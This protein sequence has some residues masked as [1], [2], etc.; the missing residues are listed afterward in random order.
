MAYNPFDTSKTPFGSQPSAAD[1]F[2]LIGPA[3]D[4]EDDQK[5]QQA[6]PPPNYT[7][8]PTDTTQPSEQP[9]QGGG[10]PL[11]NL[12]QSAPTS[13]PQAPATQVIGGQQ[14]QVTQYQAPTSGQNVTPT[15]PP[16]VTMDAGMAMV[17]GPGG[18]KYAADPAWAARLQ[19]AAADQNEFYRLYDEMNR[20]VKSPMT[21]PYGWSSGQTLPFAGG[22]SSWQDDGSLKPIESLDEYFGFGGGESPQLQPPASAPAGPQGRAPL[23]VDPSQVTALPPYDP[24]QPLSPT[25]VWGANQGYPAGAGRQPGAPG[26]AVPPGSVVNNG[27]PSPS[28]E[29]NPTRSAVVGGG[30][31]PWLSNLWS[32]IQQ[33]PNFGAVNPSMPGGTADLNQASV[34]FAKQGLA[35]PS[36]YDNDLF[37]Q[38]MQSGMK[39]LETRQKGDRLDLLRDSASRLGPRSGQLTNEYIDLADRYDTRRHDM[40]T[41]LLREA[42]TTQAGDRLAA[43][44]GAQQVGSNV[45]GQEQSLRGETRQEREFA[46]NDRARKVNELI[47]YGAIDR[48][49]GR[50]AMD[51]Y[52]RWYQAEIAG[53]ESMARLAMQEFMN[54]IALAQL[55]ANLPSDGQGGA[56]NGQPETQDWLEWNAQNPYD[57]NHPYSQ[58]GWGNPANTGNYNFG[59]RF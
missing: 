45:F 19:A 51:D 18:A 53:N 7:Q 31:A 9:V 43:L 55:Q 37:N 6:A 16:G 11:A 3:P 10:D 59:F 13:I 27:P 30:N 2:S 49:L 5:K 35:N 22:Y 58:Y 12:A 21:T 47:Q 23:A 54:T 25:N 57:P 20:T 48:Q 17:T 34:D 32:A 39:E 56:G 42:A 26:A 4:D 28:D 14:P 50:D 1:P 33:Q 36:R 40:V 15:M 44:Q 38:L 24:G 29:Y 41:G 46:M 52:F 8:T